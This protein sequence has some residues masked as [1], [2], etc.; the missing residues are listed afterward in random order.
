MDSNQYELPITYRPAFR[1]D[2]F[3]IIRYGAKAD[4]ITVNT[5]S[6][7]QA[8]ELCHAAGGGTVLI[9]KGMWITGPI[10]MKSNVNLHIEK[11]S[12]LQFSRNYNDF[13]IVLTTWEGQ[14]SYRCQAPIGGFDLENIAITG[15]GIIDGGGDAWRAIKREKNDGW[16]MVK[17]DKIGRTKR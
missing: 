9:P 6:I 11:G 2:T 7:N 3:D 15:G 17:I 5:K 1:K 10:V 13:S 16:A 14:E 4:G 12:L 8:I